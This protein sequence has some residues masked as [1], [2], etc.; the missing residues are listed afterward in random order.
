M[1]PNFYR[2]EWNEKISRPRTCFCSGW[3]LGGNGG[4]YRCDQMIPL[5]DHADC[6]DLLEF[7]RTCKAGRVYTTHGFTT[8]LAELMQQAGIDATPV[9]ELWCEVESSEPARYTAET[10]DLF[11][12]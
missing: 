7:A 10:L 5:S 8:E 1:P 9:P 12:S 11:E 4:Y 6:S 2:S 3:A